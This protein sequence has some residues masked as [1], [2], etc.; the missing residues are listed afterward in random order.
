MAI[1][2]GVDGGGSK[3]T[4]IV[5][6]AALQ[7]LGRGEAGA[8]NYHSVGESTAV[9]NIMAATTQAS[10]SAGVPAQFE[11]AAFCLAGVR[12]EPDFARMRP[13]LEAL[14]LASRIVLDHDAAAAHCAALGGEPGVVVIAGTGSFAFGVNRAGERFTCGGW[15]PA[16]G[17]EGSAYWMVMEAVRLALSHYDRGVAQPRIT[18]MLFDRLGVR[19]VMS[20]VDLIY[21]PG[22]GHDQIAAFAIEIGRLAEA[23]DTDAGRVLHDAGKHLARLALQVAQA[24]YPRADRPVISYQGSVFDTGA[25]PDHAGILFNAFRRWVRFIRPF[26]RICPPMHEP[27]L[28]AARLALN[29]SG[30]LDPKPDHTFTES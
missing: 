19:D 21:H 30:P 7:V 3:T 13:R 26:A 20:L 14:N 6:D 24:V 15:G 28:G 5:A 18:D 2:L 22:Q 27:A 25:G 9:A 11:A 17:D 10:E 16:L 1:Y 4:A 23:G 12:R 8:S 29:S